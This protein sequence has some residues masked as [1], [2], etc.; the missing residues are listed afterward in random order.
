VS[1]ARSRRSGLRELAD[2]FVLAAP[3]GVRTRTRLYPSP[4]EEQRLEQIGVFLGGL[5]RR[6]L[7]AWTWA[8]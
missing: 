8:K 2:P 5:Y 1:A 4:V 6:A 7:A 3:A